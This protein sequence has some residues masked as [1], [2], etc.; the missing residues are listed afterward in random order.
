MTK[1]CLKKLIKECILESIS[2]MEKEEIKKNKVI[3]KTPHDEYR[4][5]YRKEI[6]PSKEKREDTAYYATDKQDAY[7]TAKAM[8]KSLKMGLKETGNKYN[9]I[10]PQGLEFVK[11]D[12]VNE[13]EKRELKVN[14][15]IMDN[16]NQGW[17][18]TAVTSTT[19]SV[20]DFD[21]GYFNKTYPLKDFSNKFRYETYADMQN[22]L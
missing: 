13:E 4:V 15:R 17:L 11:K 3:S 8:V 2:E 9:K 5:S 1:N 14:D 16:E 21:S 22:H 7:E 12:L 18:V 19:F 10:E 6:V 20:R